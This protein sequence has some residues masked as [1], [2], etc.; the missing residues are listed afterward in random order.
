ME[1]DFLNEDDLYKDDGSL[2][3]WANVTLPK[4]VSFDGCDTVS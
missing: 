4:D 3:H 1:D 2:G